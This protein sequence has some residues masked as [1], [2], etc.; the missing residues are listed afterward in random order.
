MKKGSQMEILLLDIEAL[1]RILDEVAKTSDCIK[2]HYY[3]LKAYF[4]LV[5]ARTLTSKSYLRKAKKSAE[6][7]KNLMALAWINHNK[8]VRARERIKK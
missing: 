3:L 6:L 8:N 4:S 2:P 5:H 7:E 1:M